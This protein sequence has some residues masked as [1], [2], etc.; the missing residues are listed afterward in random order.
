MIDWNESIF[1]CN[2]R[3]TRRFINGCREHRRSHFVRWWPRRSRTGRGTAHWCYVCFLRGRWRGVL[4]SAYAISVTGPVHGL[5]GLLTFWLICT[6]ESGNAQYHGEKT[7]YLTDSCILH[8]ALHDAIRWFF[9][10]FVTI[11]LPWT[12]FFLSSIATRYT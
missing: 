3:M 2:G 9:V 5:R 8:T 11:R 4:I 10:R 6:S 12:S 7:D 1:G